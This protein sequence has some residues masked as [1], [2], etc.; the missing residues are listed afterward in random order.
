MVERAQRILAVHS[1]VPDGYCLG[2]MNEFGLAVPHPCSQAQ[3]ATRALKLAETVPLEPPTWNDDT[4]EV[5][6]LSHRNRKISAETG[7]N[8]STTTVCQVLDILK[9]LDPSETG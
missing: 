3:W 5:E 8:T 1:E 6:E 2:C 9:S 4:Q 7:W